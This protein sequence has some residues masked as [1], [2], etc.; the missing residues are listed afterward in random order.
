MIIIGMIIIVDIIVINKFLKTDEKI[1]STREKTVIIKNIQI[2]DSHLSNKSN[3][4]PVNESFNKTQNNIT[5]NLNTEIIK[6]ETFRIGTFN[7]LR[8]T[9]ESLI[10]NGRE[11]NIT[12]LYDNSPPIFGIFEINNKVY[13]ISCDEIIKID[14]EIFFGH[15]GHYTSVFDYPSLDYYIGVNDSNFEISK[16][17]HLWC[18]R[19]K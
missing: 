1:E 5:D 19:K 18:G 14:N 12:L 9:S 13:N 17:S 10:F 3:E 6:N 7:I 2:D 11:Y 16:G 4:T 15:Q 8:K